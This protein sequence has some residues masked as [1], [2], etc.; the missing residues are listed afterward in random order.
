MQ[1]LTLI[2]GFLLTSI[3][4]G[5]HLKFRGLPV[6]TIYISG[7]SGHYHFDDKGTTT[8]RTDI[9]IIIFD[10]KINGYVVAD[11]KKISMKGTLEPDRVK[12]KVKEITKNNGKIIPNTIVDGLL[13][14]F[15]S[16]HVKPTFENI[17]FDKQEF[18]SLTD[19]KNIRRIAKQYKQDWNFKMRY[20]TKEKNNVL[21]KGCQNIDTFNLFV[22]SKFDTMDY[23]TVTDFWDVMSVYIKTSDNVFRFVGQYPN[24]FKQPWYDHS[25][26]SNEIASLI[27]NLSINHFLVAILPD[28]FHRRNTIDLQSL[29]DIYIKWYLKRRD[30]IFN[31]Q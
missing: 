25:E 30:I 2:A 28:K 26:T 9:F 16:K 23:K 29:T 19:E 15:S 31:F 21:F 24:A 17:G 10:K 12:Q 7:S 1:Y 22:S 6:D 20:T 27:V 14:G 18:L 13:T 5:Q 8:G 4:H 3:A 11:Y